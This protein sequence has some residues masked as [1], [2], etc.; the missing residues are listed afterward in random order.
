MLLL[1]EWEK[2]PLPSLLLDLDALER[3]IK[4][5][6]SQANGKTI[7]IASKSIR[8]TNVLHFLLQSSSIFQ[9]IMCFTAKEAIFLSERGFDN[10][11]IGYPSTD[12]IS[13]LKIAALNKQG[14]KIICMVDS[15]EHLQLLEQLTKEADGLFYICIDIDMSTKYG[16]LHFG[17]RRSPLHTQEQ[18][19]EFARKSAKMEN[20]QLVGI[21]GYEAQI[22]GVGDDMPKQFWKNTLVSVLKKRSIKTIQS[23]RKEIVNALKQEG[24]TLE[25]V[26]GGGT[27]S[28]EQTT[29][30]DVI[31][32]VTVGSGFYS[33]LLF[34][35]YQAFQYEPSLFFALPIVRKPTEN[36]YTCLGGGYVASGPPGKDKLPEPVYPE[37]GKLLSLE[38]AGEVQTPVYLENKNLQVGDPIIFRAAKAG[39]ICERFDEIICVSKGKIV[40]RWKTY[41]GEGGCFL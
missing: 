27:G 3:N 35:Y 39:E 26:N 41:R 32:E 37:G 20:I 16:P 1:K 14:K 25:L 13:L 4:S 23:R 18:V 40:D 28:L 30:E 21:M 2:I 33:P 9:G 22:A 12:K 36:I 11:L 29:Q 34:D 8:S 19:L 17:V 6:A 7:R 5:I 31:T 10:L 24:F 38:A 15:T